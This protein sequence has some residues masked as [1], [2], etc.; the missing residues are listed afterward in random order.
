M[1]RLL[2][3]IC[4]ACVLASCENGYFDFG[5][6]FAA[7]D[8]VNEKNDTIRTPPSTYYDKLGVNMTWGTDQLITGDPTYASSAFRHV[9]YFQMMEKDYLYDFPVNITLNVC[10]VVQPT[11]C[12]HHSMKQ[13][14]VRVLRLR[15]MYP[16]GYIWIAPEVLEHKGWPCKGYSVDE[17]GPDPEEAGYQW[18]RV[19]L[20]TYGP[21]GN[22]IIAMTNEEWCPEEGRSDAYNEWRRGI[23]RAHMENPSCALA[24]GATHFRER[25]AGNVRLPDNVRDVADD[26]W[27]Y[28]NLMGGWADFHAHGLD[29]NFEFLPHDSAHTARDYHD[30]FAWKQWLNTYYP[31]IRTAVGEIAYTTSAPNVLATPEEKRADWATYRKLIRRLADEADLVFLYQIADHEFPEGAFTGSGVFPELKDSVEVFGRVPLP[32]GG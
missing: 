9:R 19:A 17:L 32:S 13:H 4:C 30:F 1:A 24:I 3:A 8:A 23:I 27:S 16:N 18:G 29:E 7:I 12:H 28:V 2:A 26:V 10:D 31:N 20:A 22:V 6:I 11:W 21:V 14:L 5:Q 15:E 25:R